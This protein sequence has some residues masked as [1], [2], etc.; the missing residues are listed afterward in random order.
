MSSATS[1]SAMGAHSRPINCR[2]SNPIV[3][4]A[5]STSAHKG[6]SHSYEQ[7]TPRRWRRKSRRRHFL[8]IAQGSREAKGTPCAVLFIIFISSS[9]YLLKPLQRL[10]HKMKWDI[11]SGL[12]DIQSGKIVHYW[13]LHSEPNAL[14]PHCPRRN[15][16]S[17]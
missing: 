5:T 11:Q 1:P 13:P 12:R 4:Y 17:L 9:R 10:A 15:V 14:L 2:R 3:G 16:I 8:V 7:T 6:C